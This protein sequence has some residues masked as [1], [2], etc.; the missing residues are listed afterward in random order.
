MAWQVGDL[1]LALVGV[2]QPA[3]DAEAKSK[4]CAGAGGRRVQ[5]GVPLEDPA[6]SAGGTPGPWSWTAKT[7][8]RP[9]RL[10]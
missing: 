2:G 6:R 5:A 9:S 10:A 3:G 7:A 1:Q 8:W 4:P